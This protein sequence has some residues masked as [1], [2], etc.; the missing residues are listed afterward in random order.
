LKKE[1][2]VYP[3]SFLAYEEEFIAGKNTFEDEEG[4]VYA[5]SIGLKNL[6]SATHEASVDKIARKTDLIDRES[7]VLAVVFS[8]KKKAVLINLVSAEKNGEQRVIHNRNASLAIFNISDGYVNSAED[9]YRVGDIVRA[10]ILEVTPYGIELETKAPDLG[11][12]KAYG[13]KS[14]KPLVL[15]DGKLRDTVT[16]ATEERKISNLYALR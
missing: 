12:I 11:V 10:R 13:I 4:K 5:D 6:D 14:R 8:V 7:I 15:I 9:M 2:I 16:G 3:G 1:E